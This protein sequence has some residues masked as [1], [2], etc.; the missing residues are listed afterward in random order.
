MLKNEILINQIEKYLF[1][2][3]SID[4]IFQ[5]LSFLQAT[6]EQESEVMSEEGESSPPVGDDAPTPKTPVEQ[7]AVN[8]VPAAGPS[9]QNAN[10]SNV[11]REN[12]QNWTANMSGFCLADIEARFDDNFFN[13]RKKA[14]GKE[15][16]EETP[17]NNTTSTSQPSPVHTQ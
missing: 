13:G 3:V 9:Y 8:R 10:R 12:C 5:P 16:E 17:P 11:A 15:D 6:Q 4:I 1:A 7:Q 14:K 2:N